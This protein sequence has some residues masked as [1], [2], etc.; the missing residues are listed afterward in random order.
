MRG[1]VVATVTVLVASACSA[2]VTHRAT[3]GA[4]NANATVNLH[5]PF[6][7]HMAPPPAGPFRAASQGTQGFGPPNVYSDVTK[8]DHW[9]GWVVSPSRLSLMESFDYVQS[10]FTVPG[11]DAA[12][13]RNNEARMTTIWVGLGGVDT[14]GL[15]QEGISASCSTY[16][17]KGNIARPGVPQYVA[18][19]EAFPQIERFGG[20]ANPGDFIF[21]STHFNEA[22]GGGDTP[23]KGQGDFEMLVL[24]VTQNNLVLA[25]VHSSCQA[26]S[27]SLGEA[28]AIAETPK[29][30]LHQDSCSPSEVDVDGQCEPGPCPPPYVY[31]NNDCRF[32]PAPFDHVQFEGTGFENSTAQTGDIQADEWN[33]TQWNVVWQNNTVL[34]AEPITYVTFDPSLFAKLHVQS[35]N[36]GAQYDSF[37]VQD[38]QYSAT[39]PSPPSSSTTPPAT[40]GPAIGNVSPGH[41]SPEEAVAGFL[42]AVVNKDWGSACEYLIP[43]EQGL[44]TLGSALEA[45]TATTPNG[46]LHIGDTVINGTRALVSAVGTFCSSTSGGSPTCVTNSD[47]KGG[48]PSGSLS[49]D[50]AYRDALSN[51]QDAAAACAEVNGEWY[52]DFSTTT[53]G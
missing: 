36:E 48:L 51:T 29:N 12:Q 15:E 33:K 35:A 27:C 22:N 17:S 47:P 6:F 1:V 19:T 41:N 7:S 39:P 25:N 26:D 21:A 30:G 10:Y 37:W 16:D 11:L 28:E 38:R 3:S 40:A 13:C 23:Q 53:G 18:F 43:D 34:E 45:A 9:G 24:D 4:T 14:D 42:D 46:P 44:C 49:F 2:S 20:V 5:L 52:V 31:V 32:P 50:A 8:S